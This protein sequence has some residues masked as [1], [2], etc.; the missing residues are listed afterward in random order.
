MRLVIGNKGNDK[1]NVSLKAIIKWCYEIFFVILKVEFQ[2]FC[3]YEMNIIFITKVNVN[4]EYLQKRTA[5]SCVFLIMCWRTL[6]V[7]SS[8][9]SELVCVTNQSNTSV[10]LV[11][12]PKNERKM[13]NTHYI[14]FPSIYFLFFTELEY[15]QAYTSPLFP[16][17]ITIKCVWRIHNIF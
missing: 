15:I 10:S 14:N 3:D 13:L 6:S 5:N 16:Q 11:R 9:S 7:T 4:Y 12:S 2:R 8:I 1:K 17:T